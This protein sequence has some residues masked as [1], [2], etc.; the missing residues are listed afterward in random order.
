[1]NNT[2][3]LDGDPLDQVA[4]GQ[5]ASPYPS[6]LYT[7]QDI[8]ESTL[9]QLVTDRG[10]RIERGRRL[11]RFEQDADGVD[12]FVVTHVEHD[13][14]AEGQPEHIRCRYL[15]GA[16][17]VSGTVRGALGLGIATE[18]FEERAG[19]RAA[20][21]AGDRAPD[22]RL[23]TL[24]GATTSLFTEFHAPDGPTWGWTLLA[25]DGREQGEYAR[26]IDAVEAV[27]EWSWIRTRLV[28]ADPPVPEAMRATPTLLDLD[29]HAHAA[30]DLRV[31]SALVLV[32]P[33][34]HIGFRGPARAADE[35][36]AYCRRIGVNGT[37]PTPMTPALV[38]RGGEAA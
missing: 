9:T 20:V 23:V 32:R 31:T 2:D 26:L 6:A 7:G 17:G 8:I 25:F 33:D 10:G 22:A 16:D 3:D 24:D 4:I 12:A 13:T 5:V 34:G 19:R 35:L 38:A 18:A 21:H 28:L 11:A 36:S 15:V 37:E 27:D 1:M 14:G 30:Y 29:G